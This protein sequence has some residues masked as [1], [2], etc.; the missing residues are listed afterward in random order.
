MGSSSDRA[1]PVNAPS[2]VYS[3]IEGHQFRLFE[4]QS[5]EQGKI[6][7]SFVTKSYSAYPDYYALSYCWGTEAASCP[8]QVENG[9]LNIT[10]NLL[11][12][13]KAA[14]TF[15]ESDSTEYHPTKYIWADALCI[16]Q[17]ENAE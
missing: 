4:I 6:K 2:Y 14:H 11:G 12:A 9:L 13:L 16:N 3:P 7:G 10:P 8:L 17:Q 15:L 1:E 5:I